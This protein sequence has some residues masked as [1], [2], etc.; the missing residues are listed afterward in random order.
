MVHSVLISEMVSVAFTMEPLLQ[1]Q[2]W[3][4]IDT[5]QTVDADSKKTVLTYPV[6]LSCIRIGIKQS[7]NMADNLNVAG[8]LRKKKTQ[9]VKRGVKIEE[10]SIFSYVLN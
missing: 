2:T 5:N 9:K 7:S 1:L 8:V 3:E 4:K 6:V 10:S